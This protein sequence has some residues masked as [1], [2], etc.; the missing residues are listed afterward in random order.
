[1][2]LNPKKKEDDEQKMKKT[3]SYFLFIALFI[4]FHKQSKIMNKV[5]SKKTMIGETY[6]KKFTFYSCKL[7][8]PKKSF[9]WSSEFVKSKNGLLERKNRK[10]KFHFCKF[11]K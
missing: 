1:M 3:S 10:E 5:T 7:R 2:S 9:F 6:Q 8:R 4:I 11:K